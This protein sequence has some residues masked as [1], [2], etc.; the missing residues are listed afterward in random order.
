[1]IETLQP[2]VTSCCQRAISRFPEV[3]IEAGDL[4]SLVNIELWRSS[5]R[6]SRAER[7]LAYAQ[8]IISR[9]VY[10]EIG[11]AR[12]IPVTLDGELGQVLNYG[13]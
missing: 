12:H 2:V 6:I 1:M 5:R 9:T 10:R 11:K 4:V 3:P 8:T 7:P 13:L